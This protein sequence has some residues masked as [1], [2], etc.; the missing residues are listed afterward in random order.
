MKRS[1][2][3]TPPT[4]VASPGQ[5]ASEVAGPYEFGEAAYNRGDTAKAVNWFRKAAEQ[6]HAEA[7]DSLG[8]MYTWGEG[9]PQDYVE[10]A[11][12]KRKAAEQGNAHA[13]YALGA[14]FFLGKQGVPQHYVEAA[15]WFRKA[16]EQGNYFAQHSLGTMYDD[17]QGVS[18]DYVEAHRW[19][20]LAAAKGYISAITERDKLTRKM[21]PAQIAEAQRLAREWKPKK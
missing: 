10:A 6:G 2:K 20:S 16:A 1:T 17:G 18:Q 14:K 5:V 15:I 4:L 19:Y 8:R 21:T 9:V 13:Q 7:Q 11:K 12:W 3:S